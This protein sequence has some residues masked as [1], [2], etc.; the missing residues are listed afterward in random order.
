VQFCIAISGVENEKSQVKSIYPNPSTGIVNFEFSDKINNIEIYNNLGQ[1]IMNAG[2]S[3]FN[4][5]LNLSELPNGIY[6]LKV[7]TDTEIVSRR[8]VLEK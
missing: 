2:I 6:M 7:I 4:T 1:L 5:S 8:F 3:D